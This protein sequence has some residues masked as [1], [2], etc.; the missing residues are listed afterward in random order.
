MFLSAAMPALIVQSAAAVPL[1]VVALQSPD[2]VTFTPATVAMAVMV[3]GPAPWLT[4]SVLSTPVAVPSHVALIMTPPAIVPP[5]T[6]APVAV[7]V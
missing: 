2:H 7:I 6:P 5:L 3:Y 4:V 1:P